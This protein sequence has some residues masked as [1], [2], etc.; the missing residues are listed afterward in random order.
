MK[1]LILMRHAK[2]SWDNL[3]LMDH[4]RPLNARGR[5]ACKTMAAWLVQNGFA[6]DEVIASTATRCVETWEHV[7]LTAGWDTPVTYHKAL[8]HSGPQQLLTHVQ[9]A[10]GDT[11]MVVVHNPGIASFAQELHGSDMPEDPKFNFYP[12][13]SVTVIDF[14]ATD[15]ADIGFAKGKGV[16]FATPKSLEK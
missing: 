15:W 12:T 1:R 2:S 5:E 16:A 7:G 3:N 6:P 9:K 10:S 11:V 13:A 14:D 8:Y 4:D